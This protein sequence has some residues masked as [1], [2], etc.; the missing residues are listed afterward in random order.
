MS[1]LKWDEWRGSLD[2]R[3]TFYSKVLINLFGYRISLHKFVSADDPECLHSH[4]AVAFRVV[5]WG[6]YEE[7][8]LTTQNRSYLKSRSLG[9]IGRVKPEMTHRIHRLLNGKVSYSLWIRGP[10]THK[11]KLFGKGWDLQ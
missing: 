2:G 9:H 5:L 6:G 8:I 4:P 3:P 10:K 1:K 11:I 7:E